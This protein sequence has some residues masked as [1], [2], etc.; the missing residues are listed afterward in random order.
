MH[1]RQQLRNQLN[2]RASSLCVP[3]SAVSSAEV[4][5]FMRSE[6]L[7]TAVAAIDSADRPEQ[8]SR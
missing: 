4:R 8:V 2:T 5:E 6:Q 3:A 7:R 1:L